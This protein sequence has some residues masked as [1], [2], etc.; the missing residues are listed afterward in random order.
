MDVAHRLHV[1]LLYIHQPRRGE[2]RR[3]AG[4]SGVAQ[5]GYDHRGRS[6]LRPLRSGPHPGSGERHRGG[7]APGSCGARHY[8]RGDRHSPQ[9]QPGRGAVRLHQRRGDR[10]R[11]HR[12]G[13]VP[14]GRAGRGVAGASQRHL[15]RS[16][17][18]A[19]QRGPGSPRVASAG[20]RTVRSG[21]RT[22]PR[23]SRSTVSGRSSG[24]TRKVCWGRSRRT[25]PRT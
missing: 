2:D 14:G 20:T 18:R 25:E 24:Y 13:R 8:G 17:H 1:A 15:Q 7:G 10:D 4:R 22:L 21:W 12:V 5:G 9:V 23:T 11:H 16:G 19:P 6:P 3:Q